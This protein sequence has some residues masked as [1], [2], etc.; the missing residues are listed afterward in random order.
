MHLGDRASVGLSIHALCATDSTLAARACVGFAHPAQRPR[1][2]GNVHGQ[3]MHV[4]RSVRACV[5]WHVGDQDC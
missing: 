1:R 5:P 4:H 2:S 3:F